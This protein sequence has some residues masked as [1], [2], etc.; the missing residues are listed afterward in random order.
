MLRFR[1]SIKLV[2]NHT[3]GKI[4][5]THFYLSKKALTFPIC[6]RF[7]T[8]QTE[9]GGKKKEEKEKKEKKSKTIK[10]TPKQT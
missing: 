7:A 4:T 5:G 9:L 3:A 10:Q 6:H 2:Q 8:K 1:K